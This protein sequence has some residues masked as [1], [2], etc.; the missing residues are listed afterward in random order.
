VCLFG[1]PSRDG[2]LIFIGNRKEE[3]GRQ[4]LQAAL[5][6]QVP[7]DSQASWHYHVISQSTKMSAE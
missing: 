4:I 5:D 6:G 3:K 1:L 7:M 2:G